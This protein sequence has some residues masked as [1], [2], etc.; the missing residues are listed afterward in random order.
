MDKYGNYEDISI[1]LSERSR[2]YVTNMNVT[3]ILTNKIKTLRWAFLY[4]HTPLFT[5]GMLD[6]KEQRS[7]GLSNHRLFLEGQ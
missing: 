7:N 4:I 2:V 3:L 5:H 1:L 6:G